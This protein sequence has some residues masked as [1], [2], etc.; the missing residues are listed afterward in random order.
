MLD[1]DPSSVEDFVEHLSILSR[2]NNEMS[3]LDK[4]F[5]TVTKLFNIGHEFTLS[6]NPEQYAFFKSLGTTFHHLKSSLLYT[7]AQC[8]ENIRKFSTDLNSLIMKT[9]KEAIELKERLQA[10]VLLSADTTP[11]IASENLMLFQEMIEKLM[12]K[13]KNYSS[14]QERFGNTLKQVKKKTTAV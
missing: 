11:Q 10:A 4:E 14:Y 2:I 8:E 7:E 6:I 3:N 1:R 9:H 13:S 12:E 5:N